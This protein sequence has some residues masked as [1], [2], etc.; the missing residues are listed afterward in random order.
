MCG[1]RE[2]FT[3]SQ[4]LFRVSCFLSSHCVVGNRISAKQILSVLFSF[5]CSS[6]ML[7]KE[8]SCEV[9]DEM[10]LYYNDNETSTEIAKQ[11][12]QLLDDRSDSARGCSENNEEI[13]DDGCGNTLAL[14]KESLE[15]GNSSLQ[16]STYLICYLLR[17][18]SYCHFEV[19]SATS[20]MSAC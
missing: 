4:N 8:E 6:C 5:Q 1:P 13:K 19:C 20:S 14:L 11:M 16:V 7:I 12:K 9:E 10:K 15:N 17:F 3:K 18:I 2:I